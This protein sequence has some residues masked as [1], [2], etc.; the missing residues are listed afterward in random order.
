M[1]TSRSSGSSGSTGSSGSSGSSESSSTSK[2]NETKDDTTLG[3]VPSPSKE[4]DADATTDAADADQK[5]PDTARSSG[6]TASSASSNSSGSSNSSSN[7]S[8]SSDSSASSGSS[9]TTAGPKLLGAAAEAARKEM[10]EMQMYKKL[11]ERTLFLYPP[12]PEPK[13]DLRRIP[14]EDRPKMRRLARMLHRTGLDQRHVL[15]EPR[16]GHSAKQILGPGSEHLFKQS[17]LEKIKKYNTTIDG[18]RFQ[19]QER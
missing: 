15:H 10:G 4:T 11:V 8:N 19:R 1:D 5:V 9:K 7:S 2:E 18:T 3:D 6:S 13:V 16:S 14:I 12:K 17:E